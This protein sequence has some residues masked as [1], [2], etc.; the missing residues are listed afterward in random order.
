MRASRLLSTLIL[1]QARGCMT[2]EALAAE[3]E[4]SVRTVYRD[5]D[6]LSA[7]GVPVYAERGP[8]GGFRLLDGY[9]TT[10]TGLSEAEAAALFVIG[11]PDAARA[12]GL[13]AAAGQAGGKLLAALPPA[14]GATAGR[15]RERV[16]VDPVDWYRA[17]PAAPALPLLTRAVLDAQ[18]VTMHYES[19][20][21]TREWEVEPLGLVLKG[22][23]W[24]LVARGHGRTRMFRVAMIEA[25]TL[26]GRTFDRPADFDLAGWWTAEIAA[27][28]ARL[29]PLR[30]TLLLGPE[31]CRLLRREGAHA[32]TALASGAATGDGR[33]RIELPVETLDQAARLVL[34]LGP[35]AD[36]LG[37][38]ELRARVGAMAQAIAARMA[39]DAEIPAG[40]A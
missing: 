20:Q 30:A 28:E 19:W 4:V 31:A 36:V 6:D 29:R 27:F 24:Y 38:P 2:A 26:S 1:L 21:A 11:L 39:E 14:L 37:P 16:H 25:A 33:L 12:L 32:D 40:P 8:G 22:G 15:L 18:A 23:G 10:L 34:S 7:A 5:I 17:A 9:R 35:D 13:G 3:F